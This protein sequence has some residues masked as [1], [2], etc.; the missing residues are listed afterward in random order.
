MS[1][2]QGGLEGRTL[3]VQTNFWYWLRRRKWIPP[4]G[5]LARP[6][7]NRFRLSGLRSEFSAGNSQSGSVPNAIAYALAYA[8]A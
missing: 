5:A 2:A 3:H 1:G 7:G 6:T 4:K 8:I